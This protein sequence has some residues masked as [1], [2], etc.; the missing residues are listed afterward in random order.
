MGR[1]SLIVN[2]IRVIILLV[3]T[4]GVMCYAAP[5]GYTAKGGVYHFAK[6][7]TYMSDAVHAGKMAWQKHIQDEAEFGAFE[8]DRGAAP[9]PAQ[10]QPVYFESQGYHHP[11]ART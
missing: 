6:H 2:M 11:Y 9:A 1:I 4:L 8:Q 10:A 3:A 5:G 7:P